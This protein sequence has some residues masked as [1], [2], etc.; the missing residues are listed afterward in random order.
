MNIESGTGKRAA[1]QHLLCGALDA[2]TVSK[3]IAQQS[4][5]TDVDL[6]EFYVLVCGVRGR[7]YLHNRRQRCRRQAGFL[8]DRVGSRQ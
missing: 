4:A 2:G 1:Y 7:L 6:H 3:L 8:R 5:D